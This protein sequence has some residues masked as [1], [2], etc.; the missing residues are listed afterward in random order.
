MAKNHDRLTQVTENYKTLGINMKWVLLLLLGPLLLVAG[1]GTTPR[2]VE[3]AQ[4]GI[5]LP[6]GFVVNT[7]ATGLTHPVDMVFLP[8]GD[9]LVAEKGSGQLDESWSSIKLVRNGVVQEEPVLTLSTNSFWDSGLLAMILD[10]DFA[11]NNWFY[12]WYA[13]GKSS[14]GWSGETVLRLSRFV[15]DVNLGKADINQETIIFED[16]PWF[17]FH[18]GNSLLFDKDGNLLM[19]LGDRG[20]FGS[21]QDLS[22]LKGKVIRIRPTESGYD[23]PVDNPYFN[24][25][26]ARPEIYASGIRNPY[27]IVSRSEDGL[28]VLGDVGAKTWEEINLLTPKA[29]YGYPVRE[30]PCP[31]NQKLP[32]PP[33][34][35]QFTDPIITYAHDE[36][37][38]TGT[39]GAVT[40]LAFYEGSG[41]PPQY[42][43]KLFFTDFN[44]RFIATADPPGADFELFAENTEN[45][46]DIEYFR[47]GLYL[48]ELFSGRIV[49][50]SYT[51]QEN[52]VPTAVITATPQSGPS[53]LEVAFSAAGSVDHDDLVLRYHWDFGDGTPVLE[54][55]EEEVNHVYIGDGTYQ[56]SLKVVDIRGGES[57]VVNT[58]ITVYSGEFP[59]IKLDNLTDQGR[60][61]FYGGDDWQYEAIRSNL[62][63]LDPDR[64]FSWQIDLHHNQHVHP[65]I[66]D[67]P[68][69]SDVLSI[70][71][72]NHGGD[73]N[74]WYKFHLTMHT[75]SGQDVTVNQEIFPALV[76][77]TIDARPRSTGVTVNQGNY[78]SP[79]SFRSIVGTEQ[80]VSVDPLVLH[81]NDIWVFYRWQIQ[82]ETISLDP[83]ISFVAPRQNTTYTAGYVYDRPAER[84]WLP[85]LNN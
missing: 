64:P 65:L 23:I 10:P 37:L 71:S 34:P 28:I 61:L 73:W 18:H 46:V 44:Q 7:I 33:A 13:T 55:D 31:Y 59:A 9:I 47:E 66:V 14:A 21:S 52:Q 42:Q 48:L 2:L 62:E 68:V 1:L 27:R 35:P 38:G 12:V 39:S 24:D 15:Y 77:L 50:V 83:Q 43:Q 53:P 54:S 36:A 84:M 8:S 41:F 82:A 51:G 75:A 40:G 80:D 70:S 29:N 11:S 72:E 20:D 49:L 69:I 19:G 67:S 74:I 79:Y 58:T 3:S 63:G 26:S 76:D 45:L 6:P 4:S 32:C 56:A 16:K 85:V 57:A 22:N 30:G 60:E 17:K 81:E 25:P 5:S 78:L